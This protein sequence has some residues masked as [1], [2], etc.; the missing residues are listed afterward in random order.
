MTAHGTAVEFFLVGL[1][2]FLLYSFANR[3]GRSSRKP[4][5]VN[6]SSVWDSRHSRQKLEFVQDSKGLLHKGQEAFKGR[7]FRVKSERGDVTVLPYDMAHEIRNEHSLSFDLAVYDVSIHPTPVVPEPHSN[8]VIAD[9]TF[10]LLPGLS[11]IYPW[12]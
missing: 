9:H 10:C 1:A 8:K 7:P 3:A 12:V 4:P 6:P 2:G 11:R 5:C